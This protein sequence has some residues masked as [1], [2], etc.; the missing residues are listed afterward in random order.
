MSDKL[1]L[2]YLKSLDIYELYSIAKKILD[3]SK[4]GLNRELELAELY[5]EFESRERIDVYEK[6]LEASIKQLKNEFDF[7]AELRAFDS[8]SERLEGFDEEKIINFKEL[9][10]LLSDKAAVFKVKGDSMIEAGIDE[11][12]YVVVDFGTAPSDGDIIAAD[13]EG[14]IVVK[15]YLET[16]EGIVLA[17]ENPKYPPIK[18]DDSVRFKPLGVVAGLIKRN[19]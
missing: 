10:G 5:K 15:R 17:S 4:K 14:V 9:F 19:I 16:K 11:G 12:D 8:E 7:L 3:E 6:A 2:P 1:K 13:F 18:I